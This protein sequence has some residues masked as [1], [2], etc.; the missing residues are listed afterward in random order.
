M[1]T[2]S[3][4]LFEIPMMKPRNIIIVKMYLVWTIPFGLWDPS[5]SLSS[6][7][8]DLASVAII[9][10][11]FTVTVEMNFVTEMVILSPELC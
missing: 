4:T 5:L 6:S 7:W 3:A 8:L 10:P 1:T 2:D 11:Q 9:L